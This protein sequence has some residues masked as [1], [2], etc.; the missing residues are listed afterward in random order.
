MPCKTLAWGERRVV[1][2]FGVVCL[3]MVLL[4][5]CDSGSAAKK[6]ATPTPTATP[7]PRSAFI[8]PNGF[9]LYKGADFN[10]AYPVG[11][12]QEKPDNGVGVQY[13]GPTNQVFVVASLGKLP[14]TPATFEKAFCS[15]TGFGGAPS[16][17]AKTVKIGG[18]AWVQQ[19]CVDNYNDKTA[20]VAA[21]VHNKQFYYMVYGSPSIGFETNQSQYFN[22]MQQSFSFAA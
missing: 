10:V 22:T 21:I 15:P 12:D 9:T 17:A 13:T 14:T 19:E 11:W 7:V 16:G 5:G 3:T 2:A 6:Q 1:L 8:L 18:E 4:A 20:M